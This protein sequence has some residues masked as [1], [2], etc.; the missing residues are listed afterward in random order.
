MRSPKRAELR[1]R[2]DDRPTVRYRRCFACETRCRSGRVAA[3]NSRCWK[4]PVPTAPQARA[5]CSRPRRLARRRRKW[6]AFGNAQRQ[7]PCRIES[8]VLGARRTSRCLT[9]RILRMRGLTAAMGGFFAIAPHDHQS[10]TES[11][12][13]RSHA[14]RLIDAPVAIVGCRSARACQHERSDASTWTDHAAE[15]ECRAVAVRSA[16]FR[17]RISA[18]GSPGQSARRSARGSAAGWYDTHQ[19]RNTALAVVP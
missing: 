13:P 17:P 8:A 5:G 7:H 3:K 16:R 19:R 14:T 12:D 6:G 15:S 2:H 18:R 1:P 9:W 11:A 4:P 10:C